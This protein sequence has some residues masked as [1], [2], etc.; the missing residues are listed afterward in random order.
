MDFS[1]VTPV[2]GLILSGAFFGTGLAIAW[3]FVKS[4]FEK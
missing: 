1:W 3:A 2:L 4:H